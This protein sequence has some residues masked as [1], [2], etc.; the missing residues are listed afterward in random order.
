LLLA[1]G[2]KELTRPLKVGR[3]IDTERD[4]VNEP[5]MDAHARFERAQ[6]LQFLPHFEG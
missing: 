4:S 2:L 6:L 5:D 1:A 3:S